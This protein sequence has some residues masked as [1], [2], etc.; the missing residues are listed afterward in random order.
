MP[1]HCNLHL[2]VCPCCHHRNVACLWF[3]VILT[4]GIVRVRFRC[5]H[6]DT[7][8]SG[9]WPEQ[10]TITIAADDETPARGAAVIGLGH[11]RAVLVPDGLVQLP[12][13]ARFT[14]GRVRVRVRVRVSVRVTR[15]LHIW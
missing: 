2:T 11:Q 14:S 10:A 7:E 13:P 12:R 4:Q 6:S 1:I 3:R 9:E 8:A 5:P 15:T